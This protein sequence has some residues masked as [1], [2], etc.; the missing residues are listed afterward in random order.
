MRFYPQL[1]APSTNLAI[2]LGIGILNTVAPIYLSELAPAHIRGRAI[3]FCV[4]GVSAVGVIATTIVWGTEKIKDER[5]FKIPLAIQVALPFVLGLISLLLPESPVWD[6]QHG[7]LD[8]ARRTFMSLRND[9]AD[10]VESEI[11]VYQASIA[12]DTER[13]K[14]T[15][16]LDILNRTNLKR[17]LTAGTLLSANQVGGQ[18]LVG[19]YSTVL[20]VQ[21]KVGNAFQMTVV[22]TCLQFLGAVTGPILV[23]KVG[24]RPVALVGFTMLFIL[25]LSAGSLATTGLVTQSQKLGLAGVLIV[26]G[27]FNSASFQS[28]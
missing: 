26:F 28:L 13:V 6:L 22:I 11:S 9:K 8:S 3:G 23:D 14:A 10:V 25:D 16:F 12:A 2:D 17:T 15:K 5:Q 18:I 7:K 4:A 19:A 27:F 1:Y 24:R 20:L 21:S